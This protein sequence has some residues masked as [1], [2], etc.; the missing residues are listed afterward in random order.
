MS[1]TGTSPFHVGTIAII[2]PGLIGGAIAWACVHKKLCDYLTICDVNEDAWPIL[3]KAF[4]GK[5]SPTLNYQVDLDHAVMNADL[6]F[7]CVPI[8]Q[9]LNVATTISGSLKAEA[10]VTDVGSVKGPVVSALTPLLKE[11]WIGGH[12]MAGREKGGF[13]PVAS[14]TL[15]EGKTILLTP[16]TETTPETISRVTSFWKSVGGIV[17]NLNAEEHDRRTAQISHLPH[18]AAAALAAIVDDESLHAAGPGFRDTTRIAAGPA[19]MWREIL[20][21]NRTEVGGILDTLIVELQKARQ[22]LQNGDAD[23]LQALLE[24]ANDTRRKLE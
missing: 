17:E 13:D 11:R 14:P 22:A 3:K 9:M 23:T 19:A 6:V 5:T 24:K 2:G 12:P 1:E 21:A 8:D 10:V 7:L 20:L 18:L 4:E 15:F 16:T